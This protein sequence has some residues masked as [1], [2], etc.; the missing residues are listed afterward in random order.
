MK[1]HVQ[2]EARFKSGYFS[3]NEFF[4]EIEFDSDHNLYADYKKFL[5]LFIICCRQWQDC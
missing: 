3:V 5:D 4:S 1:L 2:S